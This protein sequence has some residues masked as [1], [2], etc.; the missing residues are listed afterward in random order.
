VNT[1]PLRRT[2]SWLVAIVL[3]VPVPALA[4]ATRPAGKN[5]V[6]WI[7]VDGLRPDYVER[8]QAPALMRLMRE[9]AYT[10]QLAPV[11]PSLTFPTHVSLATGVRV[12]HHGI[13]GN[14]F[15]DA[16]T[17]QTY[18]FPA[19]YAKVRSEA[20]W[21]TATR[22]GVRVSV[23]DWPLSHRQANE[24][25]AAFFGM[26]FDGKLSDEQRVQMAITPWLLDADPRPLQLIMGYT[27]K[28]DTVGHARGPDSEEV[29]EELKMTD[30][31]IDD[32]IR[33]VTQR[34]DHRMGPDDNLYVLITTDHGM[35]AVTTQA[36]AERMLGPTFSKEVTIVTG[37]SVASIHLDKLPEADRPARVQ[38]MLERLKQFDFVTAMTRAQAREKYGFDDARRVGDLVLSLDRGYTFTRLRQEITMPV[39]ERGPLGMHGYPVEENPEMYGLMV[40]WRLR[41]PFGGKDLGRV[42]ALQ[43]HPTVARLLGVDPAPR[44]TATPITLP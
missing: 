14:S 6:L 23:I 5:V 28:V 38:Q 1:Q 44:A 11:F 37:G 20:I 30:A 3:L 2:L 32:A 41:D 34:F 43:V 17:G 21:E 19:D 33:Q 36:S 39:T 10:R 40:I 16:D 42:D 31:L 27:S 29:L 15:Y 24:H 7:N 18:S 35:S 26:A 13:P 12:E 25:R 22:Q 4:Q 9:G 8:A